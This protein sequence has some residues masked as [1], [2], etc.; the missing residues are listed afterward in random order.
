M[1]ERRIA[2]RAAH[3]TA[4]NPPQKHAALSPQVSPVLHGTSHMTIVDRQG[5]AASLVQ[6]VY[7]SFGA[8]VVAGRTGVVLQNRSAYFSLDPKSPLYNPSGIYGDATRGCVVPLD[9]LGSS[10]LLDQIWHLP[11]FEIPLLLRAIDVDERGPDTSLGGR[12]LL[13]GPPQRTT[14]LWVRDHDAD[15]GRLS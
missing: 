2:P 15:P 3:H 11:G 7:G 8:A 12:G 5:N 10:G 14:E 9:E 4:G 6:S 13:K 1:D